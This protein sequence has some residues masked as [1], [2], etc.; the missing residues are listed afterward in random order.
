MLTDPY[1][2]FRVEA[3]ELL[4][5]LG[6]VVLELERGEGGKDAVGRLLRLAHTL[7]GAARV[8]KQ[9]AI[10]ELAHAIEEAFEACR[11]GRSAIPHHRIT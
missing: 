3:R 6:R 11:E 9:P 2:Y 7:K 1:K 4:E 5:G 8:A 10:A